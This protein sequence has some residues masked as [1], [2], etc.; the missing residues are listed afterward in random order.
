MALLVFMDGEPGQGT[1]EDDFITL[2]NTPEGR[3]TFG[4]VGH[5]RILGADAG[6]LI[7]GNQGR[8]TLLGTGGSDSLHGG[9]DDDDLFGGF[10]SDFLYGNLGNDYLQGEEDNDFLFGG[11]GN[12][13]LTGGDGDD[14]LSGDRGFDYLKGDSG[15][16]IFVLAVPDDGSY[17]Y[18]TDFEKGQDRIQLGGGLSFGS[19]EFSTVEQFG[20]STQSMTDAFSSVRL[21]SISSSRDSIVVSVRGTRTI[22]GIIE[23]RGGLFGN[24]ITPSSLTAADFIGG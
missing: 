4:F 20:L 18:I 12:D 7:Y 6:D 11:R 23:T 10:R 8:D 1:A 9:Q 19:L 14:F 2:I 5:D 24:L 17:D 22:L 13:Y 3:V 21:G 16:D 15:A